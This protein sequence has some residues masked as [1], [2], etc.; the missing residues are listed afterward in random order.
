MNTGFPW[1]RIRAIFV[2]FDASVV[3][4]D[5]YI[6]LVSGGVAIFPGGLELIIVHLEK[7]FFH[8]QSITRFPIGASYP[9]IKYIREFPFFVVGD[10]QP[11]AGFDFDEFLNLPAFF[12]Q[13]FREIIKP[14]Q[15][16]R[17]ARLVLVLAGHAVFLQ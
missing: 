3:V 5:I 10:S 2:N 4:Q 17:G 1:W 16:V 7:S 8:P 13:K 9:R 15:A 6:T 14:V 12:F 11:H